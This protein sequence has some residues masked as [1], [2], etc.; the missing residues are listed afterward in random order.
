MDSE[1]LSYVCGCFVY[2]IIR[3]IYTFTYNRFNIASVHYKDKRNVNCVSFFP[4][5]FQ[6][7]VLAV[8]MLLLLYYIRLSHC[9]LSFLFM[10]ASA[11]LPHLLRL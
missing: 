4:S 3:S 6:V 10:F 5:F 1:R 9:A 8:N 7:D 11:A 2:A